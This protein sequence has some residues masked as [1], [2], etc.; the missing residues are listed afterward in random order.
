VRLHEVPECRAPI[1]AGFGNP[2]HADGGRPVERRT[3]ASSGR[4]GSGGTGPVRQWPS[5]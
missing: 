4:G 5:P 1:A 3:G 2:L